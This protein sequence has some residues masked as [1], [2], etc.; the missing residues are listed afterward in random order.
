MGGCPLS[1]IIVCSVLADAFL[2][3]ITEEWNTIDRH[4]RLWMISKASFNVLSV[5]ETSKDF[6]FGGLLKRCTLF[7]QLFLLSG[8][9]SWG[10]SQVIWLGES[11]V[12]PPGCFAYSG[13]ISTEK[14]AARPNWCSLL[15]FAWNNLCRAG[16]NALVN[17]ERKITQRWECSVIFIWC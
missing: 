17:I 11:S 6:H 12:F 8:P 15:I 14:K 7:W 5:W 1:V 16:K 2:V 13:S 9:R 4:F 3:N 10:M